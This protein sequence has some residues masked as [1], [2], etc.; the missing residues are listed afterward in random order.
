MRSTPLIYCLLS[1]VC[2][3]TGCSQTGVF[4]SNPPSN[5]KTIASVG[6]KPLPIVAGEPGASLRAETED[7]NRSTPSG[8]RISGRVYDERGKPVPGAK[9]RLAVSSAAGGKV[10]SATT[11]RSGAF[12]LQGLRKGWAYTLIAEYETDDGSLFGRAQAKAPQGDIR[13]A[14]Q[15]RDG[16]STAGHASIRPARAKVEPISNVESPDDER[17]E[18]NE[19][20]GRFNAEDTEPPAADAATILPRGNERT[21]RATSELSD[22][23]VRAGW[24]VRQATSQT[25]G[26]SAPAESDISEGR[27][28]PA[29]RSGAA[30]RGDEESDDDGPN[31]LPP[32]L[33]PRKESRGDSAALTQ[34]KSVRVAQAGKRRPRARRAS[35]EDDGSKKIGLMESPG[36]LAPRPMPAELLP[37]ERVITPG[38]YGP[39]AVSDPRGGDDRSAQ[40]ARRSRSSEPAGEFDDSDSRSE[41]GGSSANDS[42]SVNGSGDAP[43]RPT[44][45]ELSLNATQVPVDESVQRASAATPAKDAGV[46]TLTSA[47]SP[48]KPSLASYIRGTKATAADAA[49]LSTCKIDAAQRRLVDFQLPDL[50]GKMVSLHDIDADV[51]LLDFWGSW[52]APC[53]KSIAHLTELQTKAGKTRFQVIGIAC[54]KATILADGRASAAKAARELKINYPVLL[55]SMEEACPVQQALQIQFYPTMILIDRQGRLLAREEGATD[56]TIQR[57]DRAIEQAFRHQAGA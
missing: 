29:S 53:R 42:S 39:I 18:E 9:V 17:S 52:C 30:N 43:R 23:P 8:S 26:N 36:E 4:R 20:D 21:A 57:M 33:E 32:A 27:G 24:N 10:I 49:K 40:S 7:V 25:S 16:D 28:R 2:A 37:G 51:I 15:P 41:S 11:D 55:S 47:T 5:L 22:P 12:T 31:P 48:T 3:F 34:D 54:E 50:S 35:S 38:S 45:R 46:I 44:W 56:V 1:L 14:L 6:D 19:G 13:I